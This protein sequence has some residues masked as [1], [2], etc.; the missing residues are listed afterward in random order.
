MTKKKK[1]GP[2]KKIFLW[3]GIVVCVCVMVYSGYQIYEQ[4]KEYVQG[5][6]VYGSLKDQVFSNRMIVVAETADSR[7]GIGD[8][9]DVIGDGTVE[10]PGVDLDLLRDVAPEAV[11]WIYSEGTVIDYPVMQARDNSYYLSHLYDGTK[12][13]VGSIFLDFK[14]D[15]DFSNQNSILYGHHMQSG[16][17]FASMEDYKKQSY[18]EEH[19]F[20]ILFTHDAVY[21]IELIGGYVAASKKEKLDINFESEEDFS[22]FIEAVRER[23]TFEADVA[24][25][26]GDRLL[27]ML[28]C[29]YDFDDARYI[30]VGKLVKY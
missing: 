23:S 30:L 20:L 16:Q 14:N 28:T 26:V 6:A 3:A 17:M 19:P 13:R 5:D 29:T 18:Y 9:G 21:K 22:S 7:D 24:V 15:S 11:G 27:T 4:T 8:S 12:N 10:F 1:T 2:N 25:D